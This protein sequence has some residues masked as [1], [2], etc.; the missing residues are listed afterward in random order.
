MGQRHA[1]LLVE[2]EAGAIISEAATDIIGRYEVEMQ[3]IFQ[4]FFLLVLIA[5]GFG[6]AQMFLRQGEIAD[7]SRYYVEIAR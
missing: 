4:L 3:S 6:F 7:L 2:I 5:M 1:A